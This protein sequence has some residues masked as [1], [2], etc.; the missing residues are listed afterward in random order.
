MWKVYVWLT[1]LVLLF[2][3]ATA[4]SVYTAWYYTLRIPQGPTHADDV[5]NFATIAGLGTTAA[6]ALLAA[7]ASFINLTAQFKTSKEVERV[8]KVLEKRIP[9][10]ASLFAAAHAY[11]R[12]LAPLETGEFNTQAI[13]VG[14]A[15]MKEAEGETLFVEEGYTNAWYKFWS[16]ARFTKEKVNRDHPDV[17]G[18]RKYW[19]ERCGLLAGDL[20]AMR[21]IAQP[22][23]QA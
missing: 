6:G 7:L 3:G 9:A 16:D 12:L 20:A 1:I 22:I 11:Y 14:E 17:E 13:E 5:K 18:R 10:Y 15:K 2:L 19:H 23:I 8:K 4:G 21:K